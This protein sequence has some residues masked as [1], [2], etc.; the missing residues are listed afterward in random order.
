MVQ[1]ASANPTRYGL[2]YPPPPNPKFLKVKKNEAY[3]E[4][5]YLRYIEHRP[6][7][8]RTFLNIRLSHDFF[9]VVYF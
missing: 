1:N 5:F 4:N 3:A 9:V 2:L 8:W 7:F 6:Q